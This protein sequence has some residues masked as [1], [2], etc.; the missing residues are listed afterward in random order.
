MRQEIRAVLLSRAK[1]DRIGI[2]RNRVVL[3]MCG[4]IILQIDMAC[5]AIAGFKKH[6]TFGSCRHR[7]YLLPNAGTPPEG[8]W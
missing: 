2:N 6:P 3:R 1:Q 8:R 4:K 5:L 7:I